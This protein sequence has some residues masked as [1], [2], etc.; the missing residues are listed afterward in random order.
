MGRHTKLTPEL[1]EKI[2]DIIA[3][4]NY[5][6]TACSACGVGETTYYHWLELAEEGKNGIYQKFGEA[7]KKAEAKSE[8]SLVADV[9]KAGKDPRYWPASMTMLERRFPEHYARI[10]RFAGNLNV[11][12]TIQVI[13]HIPGHDE[14]PQIE[15][16]EPLGGLT[17]GSNKGQ[18][19]GISAR[20]H[21]EKEV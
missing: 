15:T 14:P 17:N 6:S 10:D 20:L 18:E 9:V 2:C 7:V 19:E 11:G 5:I 16:R 1:Q 21:E 12:G 13:H 4:G 8:Q 3:K